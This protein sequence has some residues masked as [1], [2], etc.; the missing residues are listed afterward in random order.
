MDTIQEQ[1]RVISRV[2]N[3]GGDKGGRREYAKIKNDLIWTAE[4]CI[5]SPGNMD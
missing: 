5:I 1:L 4:Y 2:R 3:F